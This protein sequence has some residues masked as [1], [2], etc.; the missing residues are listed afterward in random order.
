MKD[1][2]IQ[3]KGSRQLDGRP[4][5]LDAN[6]GL[7][8]IQEALLLVEAAGDRLLAM[9]QPFP[10]KRNDLQKQLQERLGVVIHGDESIQDLNEL[11]NSVGVFKGLNIKL[12]KC[13]GLDRAKAL[14]DRAAVLGMKVMLGSMSES[15]LGCTAMAHMAGKADIVDLDGPWSI[16]NDPFQGISMH[17]GKL[18]H[19]SRSGYRSRPSY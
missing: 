19:A 14:M 4:L 9:E 15:S 8:T 3:Y 5:F 10:V 17:H 6:Q 1:R 16:K 11:E 2:S 12:M 18:D 13:G 7:S